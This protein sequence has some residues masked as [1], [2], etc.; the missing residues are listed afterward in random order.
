MFDPDSGHKHPTWEQSGSLLSDPPV[1]LTNTSSLYH[2]SFGE[3]PHNL[4]L[5]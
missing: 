3:C 4:H 2:I 1:N 5:T